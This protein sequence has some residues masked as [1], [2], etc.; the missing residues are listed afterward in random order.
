M[1]WQDTP[2]YVQRQKTQYKIVL[3]LGIAQTQKT[4]MIE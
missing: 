2:L 4:D 1:V 3:K